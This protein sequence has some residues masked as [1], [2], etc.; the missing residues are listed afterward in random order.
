[1]RFKKVDL[2]WI[3]Q[4]GRHPDGGPF[5][6]FRFRPKPRRRTV[7][8]AT[9][10]CLCV[11]KES[12]LKSVDDVLKERGWASFQQRRSQLYLRVPRARLLRGSPRTT[13]TRRKFSRTWLPHNHE[14]NALAV[15]NRQVDVATC[16]QRSH[17]PPSKSPT[18]KRPRR[19][20]EFWRSPLIPS[21]PLVWRNS[22]PESTRKRKIADF[23]FGYGVKGDVAHAKGHPRK[24][25]VGAVQAF[26][27]RPAGSSPSART[28]PRKEQAAGQCRDACGGKG[29]AHQ[30]I[31]EALDKLSL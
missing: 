30:E 22:L 24:A 3:R 16:K 12:P 27:Q 17:R 20:R 9:T 4:Q 31:D 25:P 1:M 2:C 15:A 10:P 11:N 8:T 7:R 28:V 5:R 14:S 6:R 29:R 18:L 19:I 23:I 13:S 21:D 26:D